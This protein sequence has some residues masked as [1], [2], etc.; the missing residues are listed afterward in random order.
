MVGQYDRVLSLMGLY[1]MD[2]SP[3]VFKDPVLGLTYMIF[4]AGHT[5]HRGYNSKQKEGLPK[6]Y[7]MNKGFASKYGDV[8]DYVTTRDLL[9]VE[10]HYTVDQEHCCL[11]NGVIL[12]NLA[13]AKGKP[14]VAYAIEQHMILLEPTDSDVFELDTKIAVFLCELGYDGWIRLSEYGVTDE[15]LLCN[16]SSVARN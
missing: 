2:P 4:P 9:L 8:L 11:K 15:V 12:Y 16:D 1:Q 6:F 10:N 13:I 3:K 5:V 7:S 14:D